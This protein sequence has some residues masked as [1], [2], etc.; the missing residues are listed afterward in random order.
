MSVYPPPP[1]SYGQMGYPTSYAQRG[2]TVPAP[3]GAYGVPQ[4]GPSHPVFYDPNSFRRDYT[5]RLAELTI[6]SRPII[7][8]LSMI[9]QEYSRWAEIVAQCLEAH[10]RRVPPWMKLPAFYLLDAISKNVYDPY[11]RFFTPFVIGLF[12]ETYH[13]VDQPTR[14]KMEEMLLTW[15]TGGPHG[16][17][18]FGIGPQVA[19]E[20]GIWGNDSNFGQPQ[21]APISR[22]QVLSELD[23]TLGQKERILQA[24]PYDTNAQNQVNVLRQ[25]QSLVNVGVSQGELQQILTQLRTLAR[26]SVP[27]HVPPPPVP[28]AYPPPVASSSTAPYPY[29]SQQPPYASAP[30]QQMYQ[31]S[32]EY[33]SVLSNPPVAPLPAPSTGNTS[34]APNLEGLF[35]ALVKAGVVP[36]STGTPVGA[37]AIAK[38]EE[39]KL[40]I[41]DPEREAS[42]RYRK[43]ILKHKIK[44]TSAEITKQR[45]PI[46][47]ILYESLPSQC[48]Q[49]GVR[50]A[51]D[52]LGKKALED[53]LDIHFR[54][55][56]KA[57]QNV[58]RGHSRSWFI[59][60]EDWIRDAE[61]W[62]GKRPMDGSKR[63]TA[64]ES[65]AAEA[66]KLDSEL[67]AQFV[68]VPPGDEAKTFSCPICKENLK[69]EFLEDDEEWVWRNAVKKDDRIFHATCHA[70]AASSSTL[71][72]R[73]RTE[74][75]G[76]G[77]S[78]SGTPE[79][80]SSRA[81]PGKKS[82][83][84]RLSRSPD[85]R[86]AG[87]K[88]K[89]ESR[90]S[91][92][93]GRGTPPMKKVALS[94]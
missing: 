31:R 36:P 79:T 45:A 69:S 30:P 42:R 37:G 35:S 1:H 57:S 55:N 71:A 39:T 7:Q 90:D 54:Q 66:A 29:Q 51:D 19:I 40:D 86:L 68:V 14:S 70:E 16:K 44:L 17:E 89:V 50:F 87:T 76:S 63:L 20:R 23:F 6:N 41:A 22:Q 13:Q 75:S 53:H 2:R 60:I 33:S 27:S 46:V 28:N 72:A 5:S 34:S 81:S 83:V 65:A 80:S 38:A 48:K 74:T 73:L 26:T 4:P 11:A 15:R 58:G 21:A 32:H 56:R 25:L 91:V 43:Q 47:E 10:I 52:T 94:S 3:Q 82:E 59:S 8:S 12:L 85:S 61:N 84:A 92:L 67:R 77:R 78:R 18:L 62:K 49:C 64:R 24:N 9:A 88:R 93:D